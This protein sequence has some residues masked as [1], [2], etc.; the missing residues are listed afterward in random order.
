MRLRTENLGSKAGR[1]L[2]RFLGRLDPFKGSFN[3]NQ[4]FAKDADS[5]EKTVKGVFMNLGAWLGHNA[6]YCN[7]AD[8]ERQHGGVP[9]RP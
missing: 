8:K 2:S 4:V 1:T 3:G 6:S 9:A 5:I 7:K